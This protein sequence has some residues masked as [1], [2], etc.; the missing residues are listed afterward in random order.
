MWRDNQI[1]ILIRKFSRFINCALRGLIACQNFM[2]WFNSNFPDLENDAMLGIASLLS[3]VKITS[4]TKVF[5][6]RN[7][8]R[9]VSW[10]RTNLSRAL[11]AS[12]T[13]FQAEIHAID[14]CI[15]ENLDKGLNDANIYI[16][17]YM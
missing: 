15:P 10:Y 8:S 11:A 1:T 6:W 13:T 7:S 16:C 4:L 5:Y 14:L 2:D 12:P 17:M 3:F 9:C